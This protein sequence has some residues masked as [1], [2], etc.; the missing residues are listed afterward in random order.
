MR[1]LKSHIHGVK[2]A[3]LRPKMVFILWLVNFLFAAFLFFPVYNLINKVMGKSA[4]AEAFLKKT[5][6]NIIFDL[7]AYSGQ[8]IY[9]IFCAAA[10][11]AFMY[12]WASI[13]LNGGILF[14][15]LQKKG[16]GENKKLRLA[17][18]FFQGAGKFFGRFFR[19]CI[20]SLLLWILFSIIVSILS[21]LINPLTGD[22]ANEKLS[23]YLWCGWGVISLFLSFLILMI[24]DYTRIKIAKEDSRFVFRSLLKTVQFVFRNF[25]KTLVLYY[26]LLVTGGL[27][28]VLY[29]LI[30][31]RISGSTLGVVVIAFLIGQVYI[32]ARSWLKVVF[33][34]AQMEL[35]SS[36]GP[37]KAKE[38]NTG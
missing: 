24:L 33:Q 22:G 21:F 18:I 31:K 2:E 36:I 26:L 32:F 1:V 3:T 6:F 14:V 30:M 19:V 12:I 7:I 11:V 38:K 27:L 34:A 17:Q 10:V 37:N 23:F 25:G 29:W 13:F 28:F 20:Y 8:Q 9:N 15:L 4:A 5:D 16:G 35:Y